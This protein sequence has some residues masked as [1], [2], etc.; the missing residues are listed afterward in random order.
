MTR[1]SLVYLWLIAPVFG[2]KKALS[3]TT[4]RVSSTMPKFKKSNDPI[5]GN[6][7]TDRVEEQYN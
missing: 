1:V 4:S 2:V 7:G 3:P 5:P 6:A